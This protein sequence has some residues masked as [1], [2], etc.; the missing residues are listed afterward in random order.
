MALLLLLFFISSCR[1]NKDP[2]FDPGTD[3]FVND[4]V[5]DS[6]E[7][8]YYWNSTLP[9]K[10]DYNQAPLKFFAS[11]KNSQDRFSQLINPDVPE[12]YPRTLYSDFGI[13]LVTIT[14]GG[15][16]QT[17]VRLVVPGSDGDQSGLKRGD[18][19]L[20]IDG[21]AVGSS[22]INSLSE[23]SLKKGSITLQAEGKAEPY[24]I[25][26]YLKPNP[27]YLTRVWVNGEKKTGY[28]FLNNFDLKALPRLKE[29]FADFQTQDVNELILDMRYNTG[30]EV[31]V[32]AALA[33]MITTANEDAVFLEYRGNAKAGIQRHSFGN[34][35]A[36]VFFPLNYN[37]YTGLRLNLNRVFL[38]TGRHT[39]SAAELLVNNLTP[40]IQTIR[41]GEQT[42]G[43]DMAEFELADHR[44]PKLAGRWVIWP[45]VFKVYNAQGKGDYTAGL[46][47]D[48]AVD[49]LSRL[50]LKPL[51][52][53][54]ETLTRIAMSQITGIALSSARTWVTNSEK[55]QKLYDSRDK[56]DRQVTPIRVLR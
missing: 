30:G 2:E 56:E 5:M 50:P 13:D 12:S 23:S 25:N 31:S 6:M 48:L 29:V 55:T 45:L 33:A 28:I 11:I 19:I 20:T 27:V 49:E 17:L 26:G 7:V 21:I 38:L 40:Y 14:S 9:K 36:K 24:L 37:Q 52:E 42:L 34:E 22:N 39:A 1:K 53:P 46:L 4:W 32:A 43:K 8:Y 15:P 41:I 44:N 47:P 35:I 16:E 51:G 3:G 18:R 54:E 10:P